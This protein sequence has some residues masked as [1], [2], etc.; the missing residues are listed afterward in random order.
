ML[1]SGDCL[2][3]LARLPENSVDAL[4]TDPP[5]GLSKEPDIR[6]VLTHW[7]AGDRY[8]HG[9]KGFM[10]KSWDSFVPG[11]EYW[12][13]VFRVMKPGA[14]G[15]VF[16]GT[17]TWDLMCIALRMAGFEYRDATMWLYGSGFPKSLDISKALDKAAGAERE[18]LATKKKLQSYGR[19]TAAGYGG[20]IDRGGTMPI[21][22]PATDAA[23]QW[24][25][26]G[27]ALKPAWEPVILIRKPL[28]KGLSVSK[29]VLKWGTGG[30]NVDGSRI[31]NEERVNKGVPSY[32]GPTGT[33]SGQGELPI[34]T[35][36][37][38]I[39]RFPANL[40]F[41]HAEH[42][43]DGQC[44]IEC[45]IRALD[46]QS[47]ISKSMGGSR[48]A[49]GKHGRLSPISAQPDVKPGFGDSGGA[50]RF[51]Y[52]AKVS[53]SERNA[54]LEGMKDRVLARSGGAQAA[55]ARG[56][57]YHGN[58]GINRTMHVKNH[59]P[60]VKPQKLMS[61]L[62]RMITPPGGVVLDPFAGSGSTGV[63]AVCE[64]FQFLGIERELEYAA[65][66]R[67]RMASAQPKVEGARL[68]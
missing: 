21:T 50:S 42:C 28:E 60:T 7:L 64:G 33:F 19:D 66:A 38:A 48:G 31:G 37:T 68:A 36:K 54:G 53:K 43:T 52:C 26:W 49:G 29:N 45:A 3:E 58:S 23:K 65:I 24:S 20:D 1:I 41:S 40:V 55:E 4:C 2:T 51:F 46:E 67:M 59:H 61:Y 9:H 12:A 18:V 16:A 32:R 17:R 27:T 62:V 57:E 30:I 44:D 15:F 22:T 47:G 5:Y 25:G 8:E 11:P 10:G 56:E 13:E 35:D 63:A 39:G 6:E 14:H 34:R